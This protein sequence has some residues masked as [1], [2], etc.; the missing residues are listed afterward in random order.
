MQTRLSIRIYQSLVY[1]L[2]ALTSVFVGACASSGQ[3]IP[4]TV[5]LEGS[6]ASQH[7]RPQGYVITSASEWQM[8]QEQLRRDI[9]LNPVLP[10]IDFSQ[11]Q[12]A[13]VF[14]GAKPQGGY[15]IK[16]ERVIQTEQEIVVYT[17]E[18][19]PGDRAGIAQI[20]YPYQIIS[21]PRTSLPIRFSF[22]R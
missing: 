9:D 6:S 5:I 21:L 3:A 18:V 12:L 1:A 19:Q 22:D 17:T 7:S 15:A 13:A 20:V 8:L 2:V 11:T 16:V 10:A 14:A 4:F